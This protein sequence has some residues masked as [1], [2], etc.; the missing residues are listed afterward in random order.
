MIISLPHYSVSLYFRDFVL[1]ILEK[2]LL[3]MLCPNCEGSIYLGLRL[4]IFADIPLYYGRCAGT[5]KTCF[6]FLPLFI[7][8]RKWYLYRTIEK[9]VSY[10]SS[11]RFASISDA[12][13]SYDGKRDDRITEGSPPGPH[14]STV[15]RWCK[16]ISEI[17]VNAVNSVLAKLSNK[18]ATSK[19]TKPDSIQAQIIDKS[20]AILTPVPQNSDS[21]LPAKPANLPQENLIKK[22]CLKAK[23]AQILPSILALGKFLLG[24]PGKATPISLL[25]ISFWYLGAHF[26]IPRL[27]IQRNTDNKFIGMVLQY[28]TSVLYNQISKKP[29]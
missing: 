1:G 15:L 9:T 18:T 27:S 3:D 17:P 26:N 6:T 16:A 7:A 25:G 29:P 28:I 4:R 23:L 14:I 5:C 12:S 2:I 8:P 24:K 21:N 10:I 11:D 22:P 13:A 20:P 19:E